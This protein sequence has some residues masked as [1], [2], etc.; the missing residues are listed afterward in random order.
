MASTCSSPASRSG[1]YAR[2][3]CTPASRSPLASTCHRA[4]STCGCGTGARPR[5]T[6]RAR[7]TGRGRSSTE[8]LPLRAPGDDLRVAGDRP[9]GVELVRLV[10]PGLDLKPAL[11]RAVLDLAL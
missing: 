9:V 4:R 11:G 7:A 10:D 2:A 3:R 6:S 8:L 5:A 1:R